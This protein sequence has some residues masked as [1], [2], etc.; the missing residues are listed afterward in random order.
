MGSA[1][2]A[3]HRARRRPEARGPLRVVTAAAALSGSAD[4]SIEKPLVTIKIISQDHRA[5]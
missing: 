3:T 1:G 4:R 2:E 5:R